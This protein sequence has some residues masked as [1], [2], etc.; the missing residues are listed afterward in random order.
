MQLKLN[1]NIIFIFVVTIILL[2]AVINRYDYIF[3]SKVTTGY[4]S[5]ARTEGLSGA[6][7]LG[8]SQKIHV[9]AFSVGK[10]KYS[11]ESES[12]A[13]LKIGQEVKVIYKKDD[14][15]NAYVYN[16]TGFWLAPLLYSIIPLLFISAALLAFF[17]KEDCFVITLGKKLSVTKIKNSKPLLEEDLI[18]LV[19]NNEDLKL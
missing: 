17:D 4:V 7:G 6:L 2:F 11:I 14:P 9:I 18:S 8:F 19:E 5:L 1:R 3:K 16:F 10:K 13:K 12:N 15:N